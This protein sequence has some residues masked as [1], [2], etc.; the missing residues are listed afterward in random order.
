M[1]YMEHLF[2]GRIDITNLD[3]IFFRRYYRYLINHD[4]KRDMVYENDK[5]YLVVEKTFLLDFYKINR[6]SNS[7]PERIFNKNI[8]PEFDNV[9]NLN[10]FRKRKRKRI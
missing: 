6:Y 8:I 4:I 9:V 5:E 3:L 1:L 7:P 2:N 10:D